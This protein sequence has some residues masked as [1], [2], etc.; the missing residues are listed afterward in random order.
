MRILFFSYAF[1]NPWQ[2]GLGTFNRTML[3][4][5]AREH[6]VRVVSPIA[7]PE[8]WK[9]PVHHPA[10]FDALPGVAA[11]YPTYYYTPKLCRAHYG[12]FLEWSVGKRL[13]QVLR[14]FQ[15][16]VVL[17]YWAHPDGEVA[18]R[19]AHEHGLPAVVTVGGS[20]VL[21]LARRGPRRQAILNVLHAADAVVA[22]SHDIADV[23]RHDGVVPQKIHVIGRGVD[24]GVFYPSDRAAAR[25]ELHL[26]LD[27]PVLV[28]AGRL[29]P[30][31]GWPDWLAACRELVSRGLQ[32]K[33]YVLGSGPLQADLE[34]LIR[35][36]ELEGTV[37]LR[38][39]Q[40]QAQL[41]RWY[42]AADLT[43]LS[44]VSEGIPNVLLE[45]VACG[46]SFVATNVGGISE[47]ADPVY[48][49]LVAPG[50]PHALAAAIRDRLEHVPPK[51]CPR[52][53]EPDSLATAT[54]RLSQLLESTQRQPT[55]LRFADAAVEACT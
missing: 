35:A 5:L 24:S 8:R 34:R 38:G 3:A 41:A 25:R 11:D 4:V 2:P 1:P 17:S 27:R 20:D 45:T 43:V 32:P 15:P 18:V 51:G 50:Q 54:R 46:G 53:W 28:G 12:R 47:I 21:L 39:S 6:T 7:F 44:S 14:E 36:Y 16:D 48:D 52:R 19:A 22:V 40:T 37:E 42:R 29:V 13:R 55:R 26:P 31:K 49:R 30:V 10:T 9:R 23:M 33:C